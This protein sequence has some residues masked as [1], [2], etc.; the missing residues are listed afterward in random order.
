MSRTFTVEQNQ[1]A[2]SRNSDLLV[3]AAAG[4]GKTTV[5]IERIFR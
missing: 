4:T 5:M 2:D 1:I 3:A